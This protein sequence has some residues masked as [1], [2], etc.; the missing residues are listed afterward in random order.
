MGKYTDIVYDFWDKWCR[1]RYVDPIFSFAKLCLV[2]GAGLTTGGIGW[3][4]T[5]LVP[6]LNL[7]ITV[8][9]GPQQPV[10]IGAVLITI[11]LCLGIWRIRIGISKVGCFLIDHRGMPGMDLGDPKRNLPGR[12]KTGE[13][14]LIR[15]DYSA[16]KKDILRRIDT[17]NER[18]KQDLADGANNNAELV[19]AGL[20]PIP[21]LFYAG[22][23]I[24]NRKECKIIL[25]WDRHS[26][27]WHEPDRPRQ[28]Y[29][30]VVEK[31][32]ERVGEDLAIAMPLSVEFGEEPLIRAVKKT[33]IMWLR[34]PGGARQDSL[35]SK[36]D[37]QELARQFYDSLAGLRKSY[38]ELQMIHLF[39]A[40]QASFVFYLG[41]QY[42]PTVH[43]PISIYGFNATENMYDWKLTIGESVTVK[44]LTDSV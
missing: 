30:F 37:Q 6:E 28:N 19:Y 26:G 10:L 22:N 24:S 31:P 23:V 29:S 12:Y 40:A 34:I 42:S 27:C 25:E 11:G 7:P 20:A 4:I 18:L 5:T 43:P 9:F 35:S 36:Y 15:I 1:Y 14:R 17:L 38:P 33:P 39:I 32:E 16:D 21:F 2:T 8:E 44:T 41:Q 3:A 13:V